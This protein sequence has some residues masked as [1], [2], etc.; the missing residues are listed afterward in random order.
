MSET[1]HHA[2]PSKVS[3]VLASNR[4][5]VPSVVFFIVS[6][7]APLTTAAGGATTGFAVTG[8]L[9]LPVAYVVV[10]LIL[11]VFAVGYVAM[12]RHVTN[13][14]AFY[15]YVV[16]GLGRVPGVGASFVALLAY[17]AMQIGLYGIFGVALSELMATLFAFSPPWWLCA[18]AGW[19]VVGVLGV[20]RVD[21]NG[22]VLAVLLISECVIVLLYDATFLANPAG[23]TIS[24]DTLSPGNL[25]AAG[26]G[27]TLMVAVAGFV[28]FEGSAVF[29]EETKD[30]RRTVARATFI[31]IA[32]IGVLYTLSSWALSVATGPDNIVADA[33]VQGPRLLFNLADGYLGRAA[34][35]LGQ[36]LFVTSLF[37]AL[38]SFHNTV[39]RYLFSLGREEVLP[40]IVGA[41]HYRTGSPY[42]GSLTQTVLAFL[43]IVL[44]AVAGLNPV[45]TLFF[46]G[47]TLAA[48]GV[49]ILMVVV[50]FA[51]V[52]Y[53]RARVAAETSWSRTAAPAIAGVLL[54]FA[55]VLT[56]MN[57][58]VL[59]SV[60]P[61]DPLTWILP[62]TYAVA[63]LLGVGWGWY[64]K[65]QRPDIYATIGLGPNRITG[66]VTSELDSERG[67]NG[68][69]LAEFPMPAAPRLLAPVRTGI[70]ITRITT[71]VHAERL[72]AVLAEA[73]HAD[74]PGGWLIPDPDVR[75]AIYPGFFGILVTHALHGAGELYSTSDRNSVALWYPAPRGVPDVVPADYDARLAAAVGP[76]VERFRA[77]DAAMR[78]AHPVDT[79]HHYLH[80]LAVAP[81]H[82]GHGIGSA[83]LTHRVTE[84]HRRGMPAYLVAT[85]RR[86][87]ALYMHHGF[88][89]IGTIHVPGGGPTLYR[90]WRDAHRH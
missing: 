67:E 81:E 50:S 5:G 19:A 83:L 11:T 86:N 39:A 1:A 69:V 21:I 37:A 47:T 32:F 74:D 27:A 76:Y 35:D 51:V 20:L 68:P 22:R 87:L 60:P 14:G 36:V 54:L 75:A 78:A 6:A 72:S 17:N 31:A 2:R 30:P 45:I 29:A 90:M 26:W 73:F 52:G 79:P 44:T 42:V 28:G 64:L 89:V 53:F 34:A 7:A 63:A 65:K 40:P 77:V 71:A 3:S 56:L 18:L 82:Q 59:L 62:S 46:A 88:T 12:S 49:L 13:A 25:A 33:Q 4:L 85:N 55:V 10:T 70:G 38:L 66:R 8:V 57:I 16:H 43:V 15:A 24:F 41:A 58:E 80:Y 84:L 61:D 23:G 9:G 48:L